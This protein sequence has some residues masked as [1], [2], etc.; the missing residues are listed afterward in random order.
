MIPVAQQ[1]RSLA[2]SVRD[3]LPQDYVVVSNPDHPL[4]LRPPDLL[5]G[6]NGRLIALFIPTSVERGNQRNFR[7]RIILNRLA[8]PAH[9]H[10]V[11]VLDSA[12]EWMRDDFGVD[13]SQTVELEASS[14][15]MQRLVRS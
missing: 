14:T 3:A 6:G 8:L 9:T 7:N 15:A 5:I 1:R 4:V 11:L 2:E 13:F 10:F 12:A